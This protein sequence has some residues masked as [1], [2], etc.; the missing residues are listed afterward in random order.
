MTVSELIKALRKMD[1]DAIVATQVAGERYLIAD[2][3][4]NTWLD[5]SGDGELEWLE[6]SEREEDGTLTDHYVIINN[7]AA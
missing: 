4:E 7:G 3:V 1:G 6:P 5:D 2:A